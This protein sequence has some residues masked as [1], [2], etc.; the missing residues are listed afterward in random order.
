MNNS[1]IMFI[2][3]FLSTART[4]APRCGCTAT[5]TRVPR[6][7][8]TAPRGNTSPRHA[9]KSSGISK[10]IGGSEPGAR[11]SFGVVG[12]RELLRAFQHQPT[13][14]KIILFSPGFFCKRLMGMLGKKWADYLPPNVVNG[15][16]CL[17]M[18][19][20]KCILLES[21]RAKKIM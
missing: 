18:T 20:V 4:T 7:H 14:S 13:S 12:S 9:R 11:F 19:A 6:P 3:C 15:H 10:Y 2:R 8:C 17:L 21:I 5:A 1:Y 16:R